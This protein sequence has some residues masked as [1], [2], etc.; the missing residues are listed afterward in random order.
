VAND[1]IEKSWAAKD[2]ISAFVVARI[3]LYSGSGTLQIWDPCSNNY[4]ILLPNFQDINIHGCSYFLFASSKKKIKKRRW[5]KKIWYPGPC[6]NVAKK[7]R[8]VRNFISL[9][10]NKWNCHCV[11]TGTAFLSLINPMYALG[12]WRRGAV[13]IASASRMRRPGFESRQ[14]IR[15]LG[16]H[17]SAVVYKMTTY[18]LFVCWKK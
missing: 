9:H 16:K 1:F 18:V 17:S 7:L 12:P 8:Q 14:G 13:D 15:F 11:S 2:P 5:L 4:I 3:S 6:M 10:R